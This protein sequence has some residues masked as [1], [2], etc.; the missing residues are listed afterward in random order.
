[1][2]REELARQVAL[3]LNMPDKPV[4]LVVRETFAVIR[5]R[6]ESGRGLGIDD[7]GTFNMREVPAQVHDGVVRPAFKKAVFRATNEWRR[8]MNGGDHVEPPSE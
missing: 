5:D 1:M 8:K 6:L 4:D 7:F 2:N 3:R